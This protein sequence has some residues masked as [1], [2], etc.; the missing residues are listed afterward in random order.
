MFWKN[1]LSASSLCL[2]FFTS[3]KK[4][5]PTDPLLYTKSI[6]SYRADM[7]SLYKM[8][9]Y[10]HPSLYRYMPEKKWKR[11]YDSLYQS[12]RG[13]ETIR[14]FYNGLAAL[15]SKI[16][17]SHT[18]IYLPEVALDTLYKRKYFF[19]LPVVMIGKKVFVNSDHDLPHGTRVLSVNRRL[20]DD[21]L[22]DI[23]AYNSIDGKS[24]DARSFLGCDDFGLEY[25][26]RYGAFKSFQVRLIDTSGR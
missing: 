19:P 8:L 7:T 18:D 24:R 2:L 6:E 11:M 17:C 20:I 5:N 21:I 9:E 26:E 25:Y 1:L 4:Y 16:G 22:L 13:G 12:I 23:A 3:C 10:S 14:E 15:V